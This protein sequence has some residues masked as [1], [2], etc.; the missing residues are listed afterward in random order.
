[1]VH[2]SGNVTADGSAPPSQEGVEH[3][4]TA[5]ADIS[6]LAYSPIGERLMPQVVDATAA[7]QPDKLWASYA[8]SSAPLRFRDVTFQELARAVNYMAWHIEGL[9]GRST[10]FET[11]AYIGVNDIRYGIILLAGIKCGHKVR[12]RRST[13]L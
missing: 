12:H 3:N 1:M 11:I 8:V 7:S 13:Y 5:E 6:S 9:I 10:T 2:I 4:T